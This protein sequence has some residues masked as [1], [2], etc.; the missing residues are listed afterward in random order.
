MSDS[1]PTTADFSASLVVFLVAV[2]LSLGIALASGANPAAGLIAAAVGGIV[3]GGLT[4]APLQVAGPAAGMTV[5]VF[6]AVQEHGFALTCLATFIAG[7]IQIALSLLTAARFATYVP[8]SA[9]H[10]MLSGIGFLIIV[11]QFHVLFGSRPA[12][13]GL[14][15]IGAIPTTLRRFLANPA[16]LAPEVVA[17]LLALVTLVTWRWVPVRFQ[18]VPVAL[19]AVVLS[20]AAVALL[21]LTAIRVDLPDHLFDG[22]FVESWNWTGVVKVLPSAIVIGIV[23]SIESLLSAV[24]VEKL[25]PGGPKSDLDREL[26]AQGVGNATSGALGGLPVTGVIVRSAINV[27]AGAKTQFSAVL[28][29]VWVLTFTLFAAALIERVPLAALAG[30]LISVGSGLCAPRHFREAKAHGHLIP[31]LVTFAGVVLINL[32]A[33]VVIGIATHFLMVALKTKRAP[34]SAPGAHS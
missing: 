15:N 13:S 11:S 28:H 7:L 1:R 17:G 5:L 34:G 4:G 29:G 19:V 9:V 8:A 27:S 25:K 6:G 21:K 14:A 32:L 26:M 10:G 22:A 23:A 30:L 31:F 20:S 12:G 2:P 3:V 33:G 16:T 18:R 24:A